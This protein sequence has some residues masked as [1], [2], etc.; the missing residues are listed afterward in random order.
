M[1]VGIELLPAVLHKLNAVLL[2][3][4][5]LGRQAQ[6]V[7]SQ[8]P[9]R[10]VQ[11]LKVSEAPR[12]RPLAAAVGHADLVDDHVLAALGVQLCCYHLH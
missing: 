3:E 9:Q 12:H 11:R 1:Q 2:A 4:D 8:L 7:R 6:P 10:A 5:A